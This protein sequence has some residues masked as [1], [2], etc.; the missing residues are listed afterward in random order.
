MSSGSYTFGDDNSPYFFERVWSGGDGRTDPVTGLPRWNHYSLG[1]KEVTRTQ[2]GFGYYAAYNPLSGY[3]TLSDATVA[4][5]IDKIA[6]KAKGHSFNLGVAVAEGH[7]TL[8]LTLNVIRRLNLAAGAIKK[9]Q[10]GPAL[11]FLGSPDSNVPQR[12]A[13]KK[14]SQSDIGSMWLEIQYGWMPLIGDVYESAKAYEKLTSAPRST[15]FRV[16]ASETKIISDPHF[17]PPEYSCFVRKA[18]Y[19]S[20][21]HYTC[22]LTEVLSMTRSLGLQNPLSVVWEKVP[23]SFVADWFIP[24]GTYLDNLG[25]IPHLEG[26]YLRTDVKTVN[27]TLVGSA[28]LPW[29]KPT[30][31]TSTIL[32]QVSVQRSV[33]ALN[34]LVV[35]K[36]SFK[37]IGDSLSTGHLKNALALLS[38]SVGSFQRG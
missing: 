6:Q 2:E 5:A 36:P 1:K 8:M 27:S 7:Q 30:A 22:R 4:R 32:K 19:E 25:I 38:T 20:S 9:G 28:V 3:L 13:Y 33:G 16:G 34:S 24:I 11:R 15:E 35:P 21:V 10:I 29:C 12:R 23:F 26:V 31:A 14:L 37:P 18:H 17:Q